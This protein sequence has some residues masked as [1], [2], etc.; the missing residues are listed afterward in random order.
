MQACRKD[1]VSLRDLSTHRIWAL[2]LGSSMGK[3]SIVKDLSHWINGELS[4]RLRR[5]V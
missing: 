5:L 4:A 3:F 1:T 2:A